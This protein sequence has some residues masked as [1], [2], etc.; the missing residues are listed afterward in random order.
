MQGNTRRHAAT[1]REEHTKFAGKE[2]LVQLDGG[3]D[4]VLGGG[5]LIF[6]AHN[7]EGAVWSILAGRRS[8]RIARARLHT[9]SELKAMRGHAHASWFEGLLGRHAA[10]HWHAS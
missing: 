6:G 8:R 9:A 3:S 5:A 7:H 10:M 1:A 2:V 4:D